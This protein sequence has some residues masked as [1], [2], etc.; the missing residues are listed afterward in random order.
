M[1]A[2][3]RAELLKQRTTRT[4]LGLISIMLGLILFAGLL[5]SFALTKGVLATRDGQM[6]VFGWGGPGARFASLAGPVSLPAAFPL[7]RPRVF[8]CCFPSGVSVPGT[9]GRA[10]CQ[11][12]R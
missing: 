1:S 7:W 10:S 11:A 12:I 5:H 4:N 8:A 6:P 9:L 2:L 3:L